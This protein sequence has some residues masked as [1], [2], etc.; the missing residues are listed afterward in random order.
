MRLRFWGVRGSIPVPGPA[1]CRYGGNTSCLELRHGD[2]ALVLDAGT[3]AQ[4]LGMALGAAGVRDIDFLFTHLHVDHV[5]G[6]PFFAPL[7]APS[8]RVG[9]GVAAWGPDEARERISRY[10]NGQNHPVRLREIPAKIDWHGVRPNK[11]FE[12]GPFEVTPVRLNHPGSAVGYRVACAGRV[13]VH[14]TDTAP[15]ARPGEGL[16]AGLAPPAA[17]RE[18]LAAMEG[19]DLVVFDTMFAES[20]Y[21]EKMTWGHAY[22]EYAVELAKAAHVEQLVLFHHAPTA[23]DDALDALAERWSTHTEPAVTLAKEGEVVD[24]EG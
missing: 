5:F 24:L 21:L 14:I 12:R 11:T 8:S 3:G 15:L 23:T 1:T 2:H 7:Y 9:I 20:E 19:A 16:C 22:P 18:L 4:P 13:L 10:L 17:E 6:L